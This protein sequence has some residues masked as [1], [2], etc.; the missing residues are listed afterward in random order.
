MTRII[1]RIPSKEA[2]QKYGVYR[3]YELRDEL[4]KKEEATFPED[5]PDYRL[6]REI[7]AWRHL[8]PWI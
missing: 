7:M 2:F 8:R 4:S 1:M 3:D 6:L 5:D